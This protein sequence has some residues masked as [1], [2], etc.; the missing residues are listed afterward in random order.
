M[1]CQA[2]TF[3]GYDGVLPLYFADLRLEV[4]P[5]VTG[6]DASPTGRGMCA[7]ISLRAA[8]RARAQ[9]AGA[10]HF[11][12]ASEEFLLVGYFDGIGGLRRAWELLEI[13]CAGYIAIETDPAACRVTSAAWPA[14]EHWGDLLKITKDQ[15]FAL[16]RRYLRVTKVLAGGGS[17]IPLGSVA[18]NSLSQFQECR[19]YHN[20][21]HNYLPPVYVVTDV[22]GAA[23][24]SARTDLRFR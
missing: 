9:A 5:L 11:H 17:P 7:G 15:A 2:R 14:V 24:C 19:D 23:H 3:V 1:G 8:G 13:P 21:K 16:R 20:Q 10:G 12:L 22:D 6:S 4:S 18:S